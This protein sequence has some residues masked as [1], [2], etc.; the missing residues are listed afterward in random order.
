MSTTNSIRNKG[1]TLAQM[2]ALMAGTQKYFPNG[3][4][5][6]G[7]AAHTTS[8]IVQTLKGPE[9]ALTAVDAAQA[10][11]RDAVN[12]LRAAEAKAAPLLRDY[13]TFLRATFSTAATPLA[14]FGLPPIKARTPLATEQR[15]VATAKDAGHAPRAWDDEQEAEARHQG[16][17]DGSPRDPRDARR[18]RIAASRRAGGTC[19]ARDRPRARDEVGGA[20][21]GRHGRPHKAVRWAWRP[22][23]FF[24]PQASPGPKRPG[25]GGSGRCTRP[26]GPSRC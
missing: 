23:F 22:P 26:M 5:T 24:R 1:T 13:R 15:L 19:S 6:L 20:L 16:R 9:D 3:S 14:E 21:G 18:P 7:N 11:A 2:Q 8:S 4:F 12:A 17:R 25:R 10:S